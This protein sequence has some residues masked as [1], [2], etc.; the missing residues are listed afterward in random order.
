VAPDRGERALQRRAV[1]LAR[2][3]QLLNGDGAT[4]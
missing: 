4:R 2:G 3:E 1:A